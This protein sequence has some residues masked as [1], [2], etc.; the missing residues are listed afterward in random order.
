MGI[1]DR[2]QRNDTLIANL[3]NQTFESGSLTDSIFGGTVTVATEATYAVAGESLLKGVGCL[4]ARV[5]ENVNLPYRVK[6]TIGVRL[7]RFFATQTG[8]QQVVSKSPIVKFLQER[9]GWQA[10]HWLIPRSAGRAGSEGLR[11][12]TEAG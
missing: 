10:H 8:Y 3:R 5:A 7:S 12:I 4:G 11:R 1:E 2:L 6:I 9:L